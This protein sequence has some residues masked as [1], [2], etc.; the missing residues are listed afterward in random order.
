MGVLAQAGSRQTRLGKGRK[1]REHAPC[2]PGGGGHFVSESTL[3]RDA[4]SGE[5]GLLGVARR[6]R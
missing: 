1:G 4:E 2:V 6:G 5:P 3:P